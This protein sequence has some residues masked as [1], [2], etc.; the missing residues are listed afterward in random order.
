M[1]PLNGLGLPN[2]TWTTMT[3]REVRAI[4]DLR[5][6]ALL[7]MGYPDS[8]VLDAKIEQEA[9]IYEQ[10]GR[11][12]TLLRAYAPDIF[13]RDPSHWAG[14]FAHLVKRYRAAGIDVQGVGYNEPRIEAPHRTIKQTTWWRKI[15]AM[16]AKNLIGKL[17]LHAGA[18]APGEHIE[19]DWQLQA[20]AGLQKFIDVWDAHAYTPAQL[21]QVAVARRIFG[22]PVWLTEYNQMLPSE[23]VAMAPAGVEACCFFILSGEGVENKR[24]FL[25]DSPYYED[26][27]AASLANN[28]PADNIPAG[29]GGTM[30]LEELFPDLFSQWVEAGGI[31]NNFRKHLLGVGAVPAGKEDLDFLADEAASGLAQ[32]KGTLDAFLG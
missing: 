18:D 14:D 8:P 2:Y 22:L 15:F 19:E 31:R 7:L 25:L 10:I 26:F 23:V 5:P 4:L 16:E 12:P 1:R 6:E 11:P 17:V 32:L 29:E 3:D 20:D 27:K 13:D 28:I 24:Y 21:V 30:E 9:S